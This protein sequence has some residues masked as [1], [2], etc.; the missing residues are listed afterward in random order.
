MKDPF[1][2]LNELLSLCGDCSELPSWR[3]DAFFFHLPLLMKAPLSSRSIDPPAEIVKRAKEDF[4]SVR[5]NRANQQ[6]G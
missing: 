2:Y 3:R 1:E 5:K 6:R 4:E